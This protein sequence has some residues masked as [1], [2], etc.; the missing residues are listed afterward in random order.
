MSTVGWEVDIETGRI[1]GELIW[2]RK[3]NLLIMDMALVLFGS[4]K[5]FT[6]FSDVVDF[7]SALSTHNIKFS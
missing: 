4:F 3:V 2:K 7:S 6:N 5:S 1:N